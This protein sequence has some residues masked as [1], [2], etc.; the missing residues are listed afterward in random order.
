MNIALYKSQ[1]LAVLILALFT[2]VVIAF[3]MLSAVAHINV[4]H[5]FF[6]FT[7]SILYPFQ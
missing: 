1:M 3:V 5:W 2:L 7:P 4:W 6:S